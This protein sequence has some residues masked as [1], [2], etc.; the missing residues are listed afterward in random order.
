MN[1]IQKMFLKMSTLFAVFALVLTLH[2]NVYA[3]CVYDPTTYSASCT[4]SAG[5]QTVGGT[6]TAYTNSSYAGQGLAQTYPD[7]CPL[8]TRTMKIGTTGNDVKRLQVV[9]GQEGIAY[10]GATGYF[11]PVTSKAVKTF[12]LR[13]GISP[14][15]AVGPI[16]LARMKGLWCAGANSLNTNINSYYNNPTS[17]A[18]DVSIIPTSS[19]GNNLT[20]SWNSTNA[21]TCSLNGQQV[22]PSGAQVFPIYSTTNFT[23]SCSD[24]N[25][26]SLSKTIAVQP[27]QSVSNLPTVQVSVNPSSALINSYATLYWSSTNAQSC[28]V[29]NSAIPQTNTVYN[30]NY[31]GNF[32][33]PTSGSQQIYIT[34]SAVYYTVTCMGN[35]GL[36]SSA[37]ASAGQVTNPTTIGNVGTAYIYASNQNILTAGQSTTL[38]WT[39][40]NTNYCTVTGGGQTFTGLNGTQKVYPTVSTVYQLNCT[41]TNGQNVSYQVSVTVNTGTSGSLSANLLG[42]DGHDQVGQLITGSNGVQDVHVQ[43]SGLTK[44][45]SSIN[46]TGNAGGTWA[47]PSNGTNWIISQMAT[48][49]SGGCTN[50]N[51]VTDLYFDPLTTVNNTYYT[52]NIT[53]SDGTTQ[54]V[55]TNQGTTNGSGISLISNVN[56]FVTIQVGNL[57]YLNSQVCNQLAIISIINWGDGQSQQF[58]ANNCS[59]I[60]LTHQYSTNGSFNITTTQGYTLTVIIGQGT[61]S[62]SATL[63][64][65]PNSGASPLT[66]TF[67]ANTNGAT[68]FGGVTIN[69]GDGTASATICYPGNSTCTAVTHVYS[70][71]GT[72]TATLTAVGEGN[73]P[74][75]ASTNVYVNGGTNN[76]NVTAN[77][78]ANISNT[79]YSGQP[80]TLTWSSANATYC[81]ISGGSTTLNNQS[82]NGSTTVYPSTSTT[83]YATCYNGSGQSAVSNP[84]YVNVNGGTTGNVSATL[85]A[86]Y[87]SVASGQPVT[88]TWTSTNANTCSITGNNVTII[89]NQSPTGTTTVYPSISTNYIINCY[90]SNGQ[91]GSNYAYVTINNTNTNSVTANI[92]PSSSYI[93]AGQSVTLNWYSSGATYC[94]ILG[95]GNTIVSNQNTSGTY[96]VYPTQTTNYQINCYNSSTGQSASGYTTVTVNGSTGGNNIISLIS[97]SNHV[98]TIQVT[99]NSTCSAGYITWGDSQTTNTY[100]QCGSQT[101]TH[102][103]YTSGTYTISMIVNGSTIGSLQVYVQ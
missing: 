93:S 10:L 51:S 22:Q 29:T 103:Y 55:A 21:Q 30:P 25:G 36:T 17:G 6:G 61:T 32:N 20:I 57:N 82:A 90:N 33:Q 41:A 64:A 95:N 37:T 76:G 66:V 85:T 47:Y 71:S 31:S 5:V 49:C 69:Y 50:F 96:L 79:T 26:R 102:Q 80:V 53:F 19:N 88:L 39:S 84:T 78:Y 2:S 38:T 13:N 77:I 83:Y 35:N 99:N 52:L 73:S 59:P 44:T 40:T 86:N 101:Q 98:V 75:I 68:H 62:G 74:T 46:M 15:G 14:T 91:N 24:F 16:T 45:I 54:T 42:Q 63:S 3:T 81:N 4:T 28:S 11:G 9:L 23:I 92:N 94:S 48:A 7:L 97:N 65:S 87:S 27:N 56:N 72:Y 60:T 100:A 18:L 89:S 67:T 34:G 12:Q 8:L 43:L 58:T 1:N 70:N